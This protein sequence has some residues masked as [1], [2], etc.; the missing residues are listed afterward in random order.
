MALAEV[1]GEGGR[2]GRHPS[3]KTLNFRFADSDQQKSSTS[4]VDELIG[5]DRVLA[6]AC[7]VGIGMSPFALC[8]A[9][10]CRGFGSSREATMPAR[11]ARD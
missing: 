9:Y 4:L 1:I 11:S 6:E 7:A 10:G 8:S 2:G 5:G 3:A